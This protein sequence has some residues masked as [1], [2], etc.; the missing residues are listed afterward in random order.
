MRI[1]VLTSGGDA[2]GM[3]ATLRAVVRMGIH[4]G[5]RIFA[6]YNGFKGLAENDSI[7]MYN[8][9]VGDIITRGGTII[10]TARYPE[11]LDPEVI[12]KAA[13][14]LELLEI[15]GLIV[16]GG[17]GSFKGA[18]ELANCG[19]K[20]V[21]IPGTIDNDTSGTDNTIGFDTAVETVLEAIK[22]VRDTASSHRR[23]IIIEVM[24]RTSGWIALKSGLAGG[25]EAIIIPEIP[26]DA[27][28][29]CHKLESGIARGKKHSIVV[30]AEGVMTASELA[31][32][33]KEKMD[34][35]P[36]T[37]V[38]GYVQRGG[39]PTANDI[40]LGSL[41]GSRAIDEIAAG[42]AGVMVGKVNGEMI[43]TK[44][45]K[46]ISEKKLIDPVL[47]QLTLDLV[48]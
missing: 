32:I 17:G 36:N 25:A 30:L 22:K 21:G 4:R 16:I 3:N 27:D 2:P 45:T 19:A 37:V 18:V 29:V 41:L 42:S 5:H 39:S 28:E 24:G 7:E 31:V 6:F 44:L 12:R 34:F 9:S 1:G 40:I 23:T 46:V 8:R 38:L 11:F 14:N 35:S 20:I 26:F 47:F 48:H 43:T 15:D 13:R 33:M 10:G